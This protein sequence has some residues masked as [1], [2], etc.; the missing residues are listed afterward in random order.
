MGK[1][2]EVNR[3]KFIK[4]TAISGV[5]LTVLPFS[6]IKGKGYDRSKVRIGIIGVGGRGMAHV[7]GLLEHPAV[8]IPAV[9]DVRKRNTEHARDLIVK[10]GQEAPELYT[11]DGE[12]YSRRPESSN[13]ALP[14]PVQTPEAENVYKKLIARDDL[15]AVIIA[16]PWRFHVPMAVAA[17]QA[18][19]YVGLEVP[20]AYTIDGCWDL[21]NTSEKTGMPCM[22]LENVCYRRDVMAILNM[23]RQG[24]FGEMIHARCGYQHNLLSGGLLDEKG[25]F[26]PATEG[27]PV[28]RTYHH[29]MRNGDIYPTHGIGPV[30]EWLDINRGNRFLKLTSTATKSRG[31]H[32]TIVARAGKDS[33]NA[34][35]RFQK[36][37]IVTSTITTSNGES[38]IVTN[39][40]TL[41]R[42]YSLGFRCEG[43]RGLWQVFNT[44]ANTG[45]G[46]GGRWSEPNKSFYLKGTSP[47]FDQWESFNPYQKKYD[48]PLYKK[49]TKES[50][51][52]GHGGMDWFVRNAFVE[53]VKHK[54]HTPIDVY[55][56][57][58][59]SVISPLSEQSIANGGAPVDFPDFTRGRW[60][61]NERIFEI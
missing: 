40:T 15:D 25:N 22:M 4:N 34:A 61:H 19:K 36:G 58:A 2:K 16:T 57:A 10:A 7:S 26:G 27:E 14:V 38:I 56:A 13:Y 5:G 20:A 32:E 9:C 35:I 23:I 3:R 59:W 54:T 37:D 41:P 28:W 11:V 43:T 39:N 24:L 8:E 48:A 42:P 46:P 45:E 53:A 60:L 50:A 29:I 51:G 33:P 6:M 47:Q 31:L 44:K 52:S 55:D 21:V 12:I 49:Y 17:M 1:I 30:A 18:G